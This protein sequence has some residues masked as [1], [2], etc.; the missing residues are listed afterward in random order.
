MTFNKF[1][2]NIIN[3]ILKY[4]PSGTE[5]KF[6]ELFETVLGKTFKSEGFYICH[7]RIKVKTNDFLKVKNKIY[8][9]FFLFKYLIDED[10]IHFISSRENNYEFYYNLEKELLNKNENIYEVNLEEI[11]IKVV[12]DNL[13]SDYYIS[14][15]LQEIKKMRYRTVEQKNLKYTLIALWI[16]ILVSIF[17]FYWTWHVAKTVNTIVE[18]ANPKELKD[19]SNITIILK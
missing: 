11:V 3:E 12:Y 15:K 18:F 7:N 16:S 14:S 4:K 19:I 6:K 9:I 5:S 10:F 13:Y 2:Q 1:Q 17:G 8:E